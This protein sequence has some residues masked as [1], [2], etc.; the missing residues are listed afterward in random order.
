M[1]N[2]VAVYA[3]LGGLLLGVLATCAVRLAPQVHDCVYRRDLSEIVRQ[4][5]EIEKRQSGVLK[6]HPE[7]RVVR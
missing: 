6:N 5:N 4:L 2:S 7:F 3:F 1:S